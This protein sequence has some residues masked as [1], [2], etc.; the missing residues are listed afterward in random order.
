MKKVILNV[1]LGNNPYG[2]D[3]LRD[4]FRDGKRA[5]VVEYAV[6]EWDGC[7]EPTCVVSIE[8]D[9]DVREFVERLC[10]WTTQTAI[11]VKV[12]G[13]GDLVYE[14]SYQGERYE[15]DEKYFITPTVGL[16][17]EYDGTLYSGLM[18]YEHPDGKHQSLVHGQFDCD[19]RYYY[20]RF[21][22]DGVRYV[23]TAKG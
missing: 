20:H 23:V 12:D 7:E 22:W 15:F 16:D 13:V 2:F 11:A 10:S 14:P 4:Y 18:S 6:G 19:G 17:G 1:G 3:V 8:M 21:E 9:G 5:K